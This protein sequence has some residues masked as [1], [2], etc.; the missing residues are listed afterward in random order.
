MAGTPSAATKTPTV[1]ATPS[2][3]L[4]N[5]SHPSIESVTPMQQPTK[6]K[7]GKINNLKNILYKSNFIVIFI[8]RC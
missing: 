3:F 2:P 1:A 7:K 5:S 6:V 4:M 8:S